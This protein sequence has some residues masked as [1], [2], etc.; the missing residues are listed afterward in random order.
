MMLVRCSHYSEKNLEYRM[1]PR[2]DR[3]GE[4]TKSIGR[5]CCDVFWNLCFFLGGG[6]V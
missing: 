3:C 4:Y 6:I 2:A 5:D 1:L